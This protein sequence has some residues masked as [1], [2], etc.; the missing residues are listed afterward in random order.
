MTDILLLL[1]TVASFALGYFIIDRCGR[2]LDE[3]SRDEN[4]PQAEIK[5]YGKPYQEEETSEKDREK[6]RSKVRS[7]NDAK[8]YLITGDPDAYGRYARRVGS[9]GRSRQWR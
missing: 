6:D 5:P 7:E 1:A 3:I 2:F 4:D 9:G 8:V